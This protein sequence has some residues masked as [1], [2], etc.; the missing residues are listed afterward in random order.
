MENS[1]LSGY[2]SEKF[3]NAYLADSVPVYFGASD[4]TKYLNAKAM[5]H[6]RIT[7]AEVAKLREAF[8][9]KYAFLS[10]HA[11][12]AVVEWA[13]SHIA[14]SLQPCVDQVAYLHANDTAYVEMLMQHPLATRQLADTWLDG[15]YSSCAFVEVL[16]RL[17]SPFLDNLQHAAWR[18][19]CA[20]VERDMT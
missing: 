7:D 4:V 3:M 20:K 19:R 14:S 15:F 5:V 10:D 11:P 17:Q 2:I 8:K 18:Q 9:Q 12:L 6:C 1:Q 16:A 13:Q